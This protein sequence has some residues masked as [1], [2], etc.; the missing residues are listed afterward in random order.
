[1]ASAMLVHPEE[2]LAVPVLQAITKCSLFQ[3]NLTLVAAPYRVQTPVTLSNFRESVS[4]LEGK[5]IK[6]TATHLAELEQLCEEFGF[7]EFAA[8][9]S[10][11]SQPSKDSQ[12]RQLGSPLAGVGSALLR[13]S[14]QFV[15]NGIIVESSVEKPRHFFQQS[16]SSFPWMDA[17]ESFFFERQR[18]RIR[19]DSL[20][21]TPSSR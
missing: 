11:F 20:S 4:A 9:L 13:E 7:S 18:N 12:G 10:K 14:F 19:G 5:T 8:K 17:G 16:E 6:V 1:M 15:A 21:S 3:K 2:T